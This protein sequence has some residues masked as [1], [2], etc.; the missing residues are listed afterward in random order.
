MAK[1]QVRDMDNI[2]RGGANADV[3]FHQRAVRGDDGRLRSIYLIEP[4]TPKGERWV[5]EKGFPIF[6]PGKPFRVCGKS[7]ERCETVV[8]KA[9]WDDLETSD[10]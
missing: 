8:R 7:G 10:F 6:E 1:E 9:I 3:L 2:Y 4:R 5:E